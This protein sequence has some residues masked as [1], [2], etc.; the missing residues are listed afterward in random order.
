MHILIL[1][2][3]IANFLDYMLSKE[4][5]PIEGGESSSTFNLITVL[6]DHLLAF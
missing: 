5:L 6:K 4:A 2:V 1:L 3:T